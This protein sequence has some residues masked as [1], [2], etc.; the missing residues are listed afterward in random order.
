[1]KNVVSVLAAL[2][3]VSSAPG[4]SEVSSELGPAGGTDVD[5]K[6]DDGTERAPLEG[7]EAELVAYL[8]R[9]FD[10]SV[11][12]EGARRML[13][14]TTEG[15]TTE[16]ARLVAA[17]E[18]TYTT[19]NLGT[20]EAAF[21]ERRS[22]GTWRTLFTNSPFELGFEVSPAGARIER[23]PE[24]IDLMRRTLLYQHVRGPVLMFARFA[25]QNE[26]RA[27]L[28]RASWAP[29]VVGDS[30][31]LHWAFEFGAGNENASGAFPGMNLQTFFDPFVTGI[32]DPLPPVDPENAD[33]PAFDAYRSAFHRTTYVSRD[34][35]IIRGGVLFENPLGLEPGTTP[36][37]WILRHETFLPAPMFGTP[38][39]GCSLSDVRINE[40]QLAGPNGAEDEFIELH[41]PCEGEVDLAGSRLAYR[42][43]T[44]T[45]PLDSSTIVELTGRL[46]A[47]GYYLVAGRRYSGAREAMFNVALRSSGGAIGLRGPDG[48]VIDSV[49]YG[50]A[51]NELVEGRPA[52]APGSLA[53]SLGRVSDG[54][55][56]DD[57][58]ADWA[59]GPA[60]PG[61]SNANP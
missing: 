60:T 30:D 57:N 13:V 10:P 8:E 2:V 52:P 26:G 19:P 34:L 20:P 4:C 32:L 51:Q 14:G 1:M 55:D 12:V 3:I 49:G 22:Q 38:R 54:A 48:S 6:A 5:G 35:R 40:V 27:T 59:L 25:P 47:R 21:E 58:P 43:A 7:V 44:R 56:S 29:I 42:A 39:T 24:Q 17:L 15:E 46:E 28:L 45:G 11:T 9:S 31:M 41:N 53:E 23:T 33:R 50:D 18:A 61:A 37:L 16:L 36:F